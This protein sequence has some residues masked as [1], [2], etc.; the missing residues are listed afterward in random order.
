MASLT[1]VPRCSGAK[2]C[3]QIFVNAR[4]SPF[5]LRKQDDRL[6]EQHHGGRAY[7]ES[8]V[9]HAAAYQAFMRKAMRFSC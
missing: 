6:I 3:G 5:C 8:R 9:T 2:R 1:T 4:A 7:P